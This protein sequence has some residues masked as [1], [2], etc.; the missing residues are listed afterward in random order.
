[1]ISQMETSSMQAGL[2][3]F[4][5]EYLPQVNKQCNRNLFKAW[6]QGL[7]NTFKEQAK[8][9]A[10]HFTEFVLKPS[11]IVID[12]RLFKWLRSQ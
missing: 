10:K 8:F 6:K 5:T 2:V 4:K 11:L 7:S 1:M 12:V 3:F 9:D